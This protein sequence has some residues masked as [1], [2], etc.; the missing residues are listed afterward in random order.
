MLGAGRRTRLLTGIIVALLAVT[1][2][3]MTAQAAVDTSTRDGRHDFDFNIGRWR[4]QL[5]RLDAPLTGSN[6]WFEY[7][8]TSVVRSL[9]GGDAS[10]VELDVTGPAGRI[11]GV[12]LRLYDG[13][14][15][16]WTMHYASRKGGQLTAPLVGEFRGN[17]AEFFGQEVVNGRTILVRFVISAITPDSAIFEQFFSPD[18]GR[19]WELNWR[20]IDTR[21]VDGRP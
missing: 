5:R 3:R 1:A 15:R 4:T 10:L 8:G 11:E 2:K 6:R 16:Q 12:L 20:A 13:Q 9:L 7:E 19:S 18:G 14:A 17:R 21:I